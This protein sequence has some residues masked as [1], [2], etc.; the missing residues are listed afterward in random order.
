M[1][2]DSFI[3]K[4][5]DQLALEFRQILRA[6]YRGRNVTRRRVKQLMAEKVE[7]RVQYG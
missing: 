5:P 2:I 4:Y 1:K 7:N 3:E 6:F